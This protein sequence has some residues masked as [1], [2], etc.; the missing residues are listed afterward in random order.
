ME[1]T[2]KLVI[3][4]NLCANYL[5]AE[6]T[7][8]KWALIIAQACCDDN[9]LLTGNWLFRSSTEADAIIN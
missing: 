3:N 9:V 8:T 4:L 5:R 2:Y 1:L 7:R 6:N